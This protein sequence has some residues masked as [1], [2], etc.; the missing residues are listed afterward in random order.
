MNQREEFGSRIGFILVSAGCAVGLGNV[1]KFPYIC[2][3]YGGAGFILIYLFFLLAL[4]L[5]ILM[6]EFAVGRGSKLSIAGAIDK[7]EP[8]GTRWHKVKW[9]GMAGNYLLMMFYT[10]VGGWMLYYFFH[11]LTGDISAMGTDGDAIGN[12][13]GGMISNAGSLIVW[14]VVAAG[15]GMFVCILGLQNGVEKITTVM[16]SVLIV[17]IIVLAVHSLF[18]KG[19]GAGIRYYLVPNLDSIMQEGL[20]TTIF[21]ALSHAFFT[22]SIGMGSMEIFGSYLGDDRSLFGESTSV[23][24]VDTFVALMAGFIIIPACFA[25]NT[26]VGAGPS[27]LF[28]TLPNV[29]NNMPGGRVWGTLFF[30]FMSFAALS[31]IIAV[32][33]NIISF[34]IDGLGWTRSKA[35]I[36][37]LVMIL[38]LSMPCVLGFNVLSHVQPLGCESIMDLEDFIVSNNVLPLGG[39]I[40]VLFCAKK[41]GWG[42]GNFVEEAN[43]GVGR[44]ISGDWLRI[45]MVYVQPVI[46]AVVYLVGYWNYFAGQA[47][48]IR[49]TWMIIAVLLLALIYWISS[50]KPAAKKN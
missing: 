7:L 41:N 25:Y 4:G 18:L 33:E 6:A 26:D 28:V 9:A 5:P 45:Y 49:A 47:T 23:I 15:L 40:F 16:M 21:Q 11:Y 44:K 46:I 3:K 50:G 48:W 39:L 10:M 24:L 36:I 29:F 1:W 42:Y 20:G 19:A 13:F 37:N 2:G 27:L 34:C 12:Y 31:T 14:T 35:V 30:L 17:L 43:K 38:I 8:E 22:L 32:Y